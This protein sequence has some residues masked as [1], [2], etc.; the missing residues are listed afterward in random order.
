LL[1]S[2]VAYVFLVGLSLEMEEIKLRDG[3]RGVFNERIEKI[4]NSIY[5]ACQKLES[6][7][8]IKR[9]LIARKKEVI[10]WLCK[11]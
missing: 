8:R 9:R 5:S 10:E 2:F 3:L 11:F 6:E 7:E 1:I 4:E